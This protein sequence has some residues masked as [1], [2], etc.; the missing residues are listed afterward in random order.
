M[1]IVF[2]Q[3]GFPDRAQQVYERSLEI[4]R[5][6]GEKGLVSTNLNNLANLLQVKGD[7]ERAWKMREEALT[8]SR[9]LGEK[10]TVARLLSNMGGEQE[11]RGELPRARELFEECLSTYQAVNDKR[12][13]AVALRGLGN[14]LRGQGKLDDST[15]RLEEALSLFRAVGETTDVAYTQFSLGDVLFARGNLND[16]RS[17][18]DEASTAFRKI[19]QRAAIADGNIALAIIELEEKRFAQAERLARQAVEEYGRQK[20]STESFGQA[21][22][23][24]ALM[25][26]KKLPAAEAAV[27]RAEAVSRSVQN[28]LYRSYV[29]T[30][31]AQLHA[32]TAARRNLPADL[33]NLK[34]T[35][36][37][38]TRSGAVDLQ[39]DL[40]FALAE[41]EIQYGSAPAGRTQL[42]AL[43]KDAVSI[44]YGLIARKAA[45]ALGK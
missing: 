41:L 44:G 5:E 12:G 27:T 43:Q 33:E 13:V 3:Q 10:R 40:R 18:Y 20:S 45:A 29:F 38:V 8:I 22:L 17:R 26:Q 28:Q 9:E 21:V 11:R 14:V 23:A 37:E 25:A 36:D 30:S 4:S 1:G 35:L 7:L 34:R 32:A 2:R 31:A 16:A 6:I 39:L 19:G 42:A 15:K 24:R